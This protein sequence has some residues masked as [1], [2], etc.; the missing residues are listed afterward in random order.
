M[1]IVGTMAGAGLAI[2]LAP[3]LAHDHVA[4][5]L[6]VLIFA[7]VGGIGSL[8][9]QH[10]YAWL[11]MGITANLVLMGSLTDPPAAFS[12]GVY[13]IMEVIVGMTVALAIT[14][15]LAPDSP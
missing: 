1:R 15:V 7:T 13:R 12:L 14:A 4:G 9:S 3:V 10:G 2:L 5:S 11:F 8:V 6:L